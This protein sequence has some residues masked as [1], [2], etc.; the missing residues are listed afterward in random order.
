[1]NKHSISLLIREATSPRSRPFSD[2]QVAQL[3]QSRRPD[4][5]A[6]PDDR[7]F[8]FSLWIHWVRGHNVTRPY[9]RVQLWPCSG[10]LQANARPAFQPRPAPIFGVLGG[11]SPILS[12]LQSGATSG[13]A[14]NR[15]E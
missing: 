14:V 10:K 13:L 11:W 8:H 1:M 3:L 2:G 12:V 7:L 9:S 6:Y 4:S 5:D 15:S